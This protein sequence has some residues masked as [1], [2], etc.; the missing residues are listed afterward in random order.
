MHKYIPICRCRGCT[1]TQKAFQRGL[2]DLYLQVLQ[3]KWEI[4][5]EDLGVK[6]AEVDGEGWDFP[7]PF[8]DPPEL[9]QK[10]TLATHSVDNHYVKRTAKDTMSLT[11]G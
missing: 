7:D 10:H 8:T 1:F 3:A 6:T 2:A 11:K 4:G 9:R 5:F